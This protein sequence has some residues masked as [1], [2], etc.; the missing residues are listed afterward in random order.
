MQTQPGL[1]QP[2]GPLQVDTNTTPLVVFRLNEFPSAGKN[3]GTAQ[4]DHRYLND[5]PG[6][7]DPTSE[8]LA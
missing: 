5:V 8:R 3:D 6:L 4:I 1:D 7:E 2:E